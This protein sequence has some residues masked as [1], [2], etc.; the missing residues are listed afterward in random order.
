M[1]TFQNKGK[2][3][4]SL[5][6]FIVLEWKT[7]RCRPKLGDKQH[8]KRYLY[9][10][11]SKRKQAHGCLSLDASHAS[12]EGNISVI[13]FAKNIAIL[14][15]IKCRTRNHTELEGIGRIARLR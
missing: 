2:N 12:E 5:R 11:V 3:E 8:V 4:T 7:E 14:L 1:E 13:A 9:Y 10:I 15:F 6:N